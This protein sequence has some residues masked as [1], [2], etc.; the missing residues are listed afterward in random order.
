MSLPDEPEHWTFGGLERLEDG[1]FPDAELVQLL[2]AGTDNVSGK[3]S[4]KPCWCRPVTIAYRYSW[5]LGAFGAKNIPRV[6]KAIEVHGIQQGRQWGLA[7]LN[8]FRQFFKLKSYTT[9]GQSTVTS[10]PS[11]ADLISV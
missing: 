7:T 2:Q 10:L 8:E 6:F 11:I 1:S 4:S 3:Y 9:F 5:N